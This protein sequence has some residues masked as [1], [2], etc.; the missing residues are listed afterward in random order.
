M[1]IKKLMEEKAFRLK[2]IENLHSE[3]KGLE[4]AIRLMNGEDDT[5]VSQN[6]GSPKQRARNVK[7]TVLSIVTSSESAGVTVNELMNKAKTDGVALE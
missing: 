3:I 2:Q 1:N 7:G 5:D 6:N 4:V